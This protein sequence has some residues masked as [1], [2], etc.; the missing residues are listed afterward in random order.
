ME[1]ASNRLKV[2]AILVA[3]MFVGLMTRLWFLQVLAGERFSQE[4]TNNS[5]R[6][7]YTE[8]LRGLI[9]DRNGKELV[10]NQQSV[11]IRIT[12]DELG[13][14]GEAV[15]GRLAELLEVRPAELSTE[16]NTNRYYTFQ[17]VPVAEF[18]PEEVAYYVEERPELFPGVDVNLAS[19]RRYPEGR[20]A[21]H[22]LGYMGLVT[23]DALKSVNAKAYGP[24]DAIG[25]AGL[26][27]MYERF[28]R[29]ERGI[30]KT[31][32]N[33]D[34]ETIRALDAIPATAGDDLHLTLDARWQEIA[35]RR[36]AEG[37]DHAHQIND[38]NGQALRA[39]GGAVVILDAHTG[40]IRAIA[41]LP[42]YDPRWYVR[43]LSPR[44]AAYLRNGDRAAALDRAT[45]PYTPGSTFK[46]ITALITAQQGFANLYGYYPCTTSYVHGIDEEHPFFNWT[47]T[48]GNSISFADALRQSC[49]TFFY[50]FGSK[51]FQ[52]YVDHQL[53]NDAQPLQKGIR[54]WGFGAPTG[55]DLPLESSGQI[56]D[57]QFAAAHPELYEDGRWQ[58]F[59]D[60]LTMTGAGDLQVTPLQ[61][62]S[63]YAAIA[64]GGHLCRPHLVER[65][66]DADGKVVKVPGSGCDR[67]L[68][69]SQRDLGYI[70][71]ALA[72]VVSGGTASCAFSGFPLSQIPVAGKTGTAERGTE[73]YQDTSWFASMVGP[74]ADPDYVV[75]TMVEQGGFGAQVAAPITRGI[76]EEIEGLG[77]QP[78]YGCVLPSTEDE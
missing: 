14:Q 29:G 28:L 65:I 69:Y 26:E 10:D 9:L 18:V 17:A 31:I 38:S 49:D 24:N 19:V 47:E 42:D 45:F 54:Q 66:E 77:Y 63:A 71:G 78:R 16:I 41:S 6:F 74:T 20:L 25:I 76:I 2:L 21:A 11:E 59:G 57:A 22:V 70:R 58:P 73:T 39:T 23:E 53:S 5:V 40:G 32:V 56:P 43:G 4:A 35:E 68:P 3:L 55:V 12:R 1:R 46:S 48:P 36:L 33:A 15:V 8:P 30:Q 64:N 62:A 27:L 50:Q 13:D 72:N 7:E 61:L 37:M 60:I 52:H 75:V 44:Q 67:T 34:G 51:Y